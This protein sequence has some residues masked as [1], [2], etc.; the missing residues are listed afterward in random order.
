M[1]AGC[2]FHGISFTHKGLP[3]QR[4]PGTRSGEGELWLCEAAAFPSPPVQSRALLLPEED[5]R[6]V[7]HSPVTESRK[8]GGGFVL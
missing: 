1:A 2:L 7:K 3:G 8:E 5:G 6:V 4:G